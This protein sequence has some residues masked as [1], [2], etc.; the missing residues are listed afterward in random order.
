MA[1][2]EQ[3]QPQ[4]LPPQSPPQE[5]QPDTEQPT[6]SD[7][8][9]EATSAADAQQQQAT[10]EDTAAPAGEVEG[11]I[12]AAPATDPDH[13]TTVVRGED[14]E[15]AARTAAIFDEDD[16]DE[17]QT[18][19][20]S[21]RK[22]DARDASNADDPD[23][24][25]IRKKKKKRHHSPDEPAAARHASG[26]PEMEPEEEE[27]PY[28]NMTEA[29]IRRARTDRLIDEALRAGKKKAPRKRAGEDD[30]DL[31]ADEEVAQLRREMVN[32]ADDDEEA[33]RLKKPATNK[34]K[35]LPKVVATLQK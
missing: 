2:E 10:E 3:Q 35:L 5:Q 31:L 18:D 13:L 27:D 21:F 8:V 23:A 24:A 4:E 29:E 22:R 6:A 32:A 25:I 33:N 26:E 19:L 14:T 12:D 15:A 30:L 20:P 17:D 1:D 28:A 34:L 9:P 7:L 16:E 11:S